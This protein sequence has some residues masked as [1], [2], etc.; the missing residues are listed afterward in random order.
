IRHYFNSVIAKEAPTA[1][2]DPDLPAAIDKAQR[3]LGP[4]P[5][6]EST[7]LFGAQT[8]PAWVEWNNARNALKAQQQQLADSQTN[9]AKWNEYVATMGSP[10]AAYASIQDRMK[11]DFIARFQKSYPTVAGKPLKVGKQSIANAERHVGFLDPAARAKMQEEERR[12]NDSARNRARGRYA[13]GSIKEKVDRIL[14]QQEIERQNQIGFLAN[15]KPQAPSLGDRLSLG[16]RAENQL[17]SLMENVGRNLG[18]QPEQPIDLRFDMSMNGKDIARQRTI[19]GFQA[20]K[21]IGAFLGV[22][23]GK[24]NISIGA[25]T[26]TASDPKSGVKRGIWAVPSQVVGQFHG[27][28]A[29]VVKPGTFNWHANPAG[30]AAERLAAHRDPSTHMVVVTHQ[31]LRDDMLRLLGDHWG[32]TSDSAA[33]RFMGLGRKERA[34]ALKEAWGKEGI[35]YQASFFDEGHTLLDRRGKEDSKL[36][37]VLQAISDNTSHYMAMTADPAKNDISEI[38]SQLD[39]IYT[40][41]RYGDDQAWHKRYGLNTS[42]SREALKREVQSRFFNSHITPPIKATHNELSAQLHPEQ[43]RDY[44]AVMSNYDRARAARIRGEIDVA[45]IKALSPRSFEGVAADKELATARK[46]SDN[47]GIIRDAALHRAINMAPPEKNGKIQAILKK[48][49]GHNA[50]DKPVVLFAH[51]LEAVAHLENALKGAGHRVVTLTGEHS[52][53]EKDQRRQMF[54]P[55]K[56]TEP[57][58]DV[59]VLSDAGATGLNLQRGQTLIQYDTPMT[60]MVHEQRNGRINRVGQTQD[61]DLFDVVTPTPFEQRARN[62]LARK[63]DLRSIFTDP[64]EGLD[65][66]GLAGYIGRARAQRLDNPPRVAA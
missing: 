36:S 25:F 6:K 19:K 62:R 59:F 27:E 61:V 18:S 4:E 54:Q 35:D 44:D 30:G 15:D 23:S 57:K 58:A 8:N 43:Q 53:A 22:G 52:T 13:A 17:R 33:E 7:G 21:R 65:D 16:L 14:Q 55:Q 45:A 56:G 32:V 50:K 42:A 20:G 31:S 64:G 2:T 24:T 37:A 11:N 9:F 47:L 10:Q 29:K 34:A 48:L 51:N 41:G 60:A 12:L 66:Q 28:L 38:R 3:E 49:E 39:K 5:A 46:L 40:D 26:A 63:G 1:A